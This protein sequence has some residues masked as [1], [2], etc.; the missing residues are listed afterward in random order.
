[1]QK[2]RAERGRSG[3]VNTVVMK[4]DRGFLDEKEWQ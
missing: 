2:D 3:W 4:F 1:M